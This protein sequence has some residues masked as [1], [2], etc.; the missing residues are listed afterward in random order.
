MQKERIQL[1]HELQTTASGAAEDKLDVAIFAGGCFWCMEPPFEKLEG[2]TSVVSGYTGGEETYPLYEDVAAG[3]TGHLEAVRIHYHPD[4]IDYA[5]LLQ[6]FWRQIDPTDPDG[7]FVDRGQQYSSAIFYLNQAQKELAEA[8]KDELVASDRFDK[9]IVTP[10]LEAL[11]FYE[12]EDYHQN[13]YKKNSLQYQFYRNR[14]GRDAFLD[15]HWGAD[16]EL[17]LP[18][19]LTDYSMTESDKEKRITQL[20]DVQYA[21]TQE[22]ATERAYQNEYWDHYEDGIYVDI[23]SGEPL[24]SSTDQYDSKTGWPSFTKPLEPSHITYHEDRKLHAVRIEVRSHYADSHLG[25]VFDDGPAPTGFRYCMNSAAMDF[26]PKAELEERGY[27][28]YLS[29]FAE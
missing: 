3:R 6:V 4:L 8:S 23:V 22:D 9:P 21:V 10:I 14:S 1:I 19:K 16:R 25:H 24:F 7:Q 12:A 28:Q 26:I 2:V 13:Y 15:E 29:L 11:P 17:D 5:D 20:T 27:E 18:S